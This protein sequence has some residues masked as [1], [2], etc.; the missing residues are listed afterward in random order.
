MWIIAKTKKNQKQSVKNE[1]NK[2]MNSQCDFYEPFYEMILYS[3]KNKKV[4]KKKISLFGNYIFCFHEKFNKINAL[5]KMNF[6]KGMQY[7]LRGSEKDHLEIDNFIR[8]CK[9][10]E[11]S[12]GIL[13]NSFFFN[14][15]VN[16]KDKSFGPISNIMYDAVKVVGNKM[17]A[18]LGN[19]KLIFDK[20]SKYCCYKI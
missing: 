11:N 15:A 10:N 19:I 14:S 20:D 5:N 18:Q 6:L 3:H 7:V 2:L 1:I 9:K 13:N 16:K 17:W 12:Y 4:L 8:Y